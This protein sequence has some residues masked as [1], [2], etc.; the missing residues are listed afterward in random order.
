MCLSNIHCSVV[1]GSMCLSNIHC[2]VVL[3]SMCLSHIH[4]S[5]FGPGFH[6]SLT[7]SLLCG[8]GF[9]V[10]VTHPLLCVWVPCVSTHPLLCVWV[11]HDTSCS[12]VSWFEG[13]FMFKIKHEMQRFIPETGLNLV[14]PQYSPTILVWC[15]QTDS[16]SKFD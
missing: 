3:G 2:S 15:T 16:R 13:F 8:P 1:L 6:V 5:V 7:H 10:S 12:H 9:H 11:P 14:A 4:C